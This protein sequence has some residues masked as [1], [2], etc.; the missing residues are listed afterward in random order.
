MAEKLP[1]YCANAV[2]S[3]GALSVPCQWITAIPAVLSDAAVRHT[4]NRL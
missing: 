3:A 2:G 4:L 1:V